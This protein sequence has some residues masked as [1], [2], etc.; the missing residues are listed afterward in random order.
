[1]TDSVEPGAELEVAWLG[2][3]TN[4]I[5]L[6]GVRVLTD[7]VFRDSVAHLR[8]HSDPATLDPGPVDAVLVSH[9]HH[10]HLDLPSLRRLPRGTPLV[11][12]RGTAKLVARSA[13]GDV[14]EMVPG[15]DIDIGGM[16]VTAV[17]ADHGPGRTGRRV[18]GRPLGFVME[19]DGRVVYFPGDTDLHEM[20]ADL[21]APDVAL[22]PIWGWGRSL[23]PGHLDPERAAQAA[24]L[25]RAGL[26]LPIHWGT[27]APVGLRSSAPAWLHQPADRFREAMER[28]A[29]DTKLTVVAPG[30]GPVTIATA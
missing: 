7:P 4:D 30:S 8:R 2:H 27:F 10:D 21:P 29:P 3:A 28:H 26:V 20:M 5:R 11:V 22:L 15:D 19:K 6:G 16:R 25:L 24:A 9:L 23:G 17:E 14:V 18:S 13:P 1:M 12:P